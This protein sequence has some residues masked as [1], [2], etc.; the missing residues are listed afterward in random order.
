MMTRLPE[1]AE[2][3]SSRMYVLDLILN[4]HLNLFLVLGIVRST[5]QFC[6]RILLLRK[7]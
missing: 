2:L 5:L 1:S 3:T 6:V 4:D 7:K